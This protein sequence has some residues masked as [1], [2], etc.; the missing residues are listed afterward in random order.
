MGRKKNKPQIVLIASIV[1]VSMALSLIYVG[2][3]MMAD[4]ILDMQLDKGGR[5]AAFFVIIFILGISLF[6]LH[7]RMPSKTKVI[8]KVYVN[9]IPSNFLSAVIGGFAIAFIV[10]LVAFEI[11]NAVFKEAYLIMGDIVLMSFAIA[12]VCVLFAD[13]TI[14]NHSAT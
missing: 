6:V 5:L 9:S 8:G 1:S 3:R 12:G 10:N 4:W 11:I 2:T 7:R 13:H 14:K